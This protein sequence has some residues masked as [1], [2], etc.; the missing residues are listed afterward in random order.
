MHKI[1]NLYTQILFAMLS[2]LP[3]KVLASGIPALDEA[4]AKLEHKIDAIRN[5]PVIGMVSYAGGALV[6][7]VGLILVV[8]LLIMML[9]NKR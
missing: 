7:F 5:S 1:K 8:F 6:V 9:N 4:Q 3:A 2:L